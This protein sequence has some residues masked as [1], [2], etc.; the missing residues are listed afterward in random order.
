MLFRRINRDA[1]ERIFIVMQANETGLAA[2]DVAQLELTAA[3]VDGIKIAQPNTAE[4]TAAIGIVDSAIANG[5]FG[6]VQTYGYRSTSRIFL[7]NTSVALA[8][9]LLAVAGQDYLNSVA[10][11]TTSSADVTLQP[12][13]AVLLETIVSSSASGTV[14]KKIWLKTM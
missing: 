9:Y 14:S 4:L 6:L 8:Q 13:I 12:V 11:S 10:S 1:G 7:T 2:D 5:G 3:S